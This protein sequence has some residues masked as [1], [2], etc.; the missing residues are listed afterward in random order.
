VAV[1]EGVQNFIDHAEVVVTLELVFHI[2]EIFIEGIQAAGHEFADVQT[3]GG[4]GL[5][6]FAGRFDD[7]EGGGF[8]GADTGGMG[9]AEQDSHFAEDGAGF[10]GG[11]D[12]DII[13]QDFDGA[14]DE[15]EKHLGCFVL[16]DE[17][18]AG[19][20]APDFAVFE[21]FEYGGH[22][23]TNS[24]GGWNGGKVFLEGDGISGGQ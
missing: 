17:I 4:G 15:K 12:A 6:E 1:H 16:T 14:L 2:D 22:P 21:R 3:D 5:Q 24:S 19:V 20:N 11:G 8:D 18:L 7:I 13:L 9:D 10:G 23:C